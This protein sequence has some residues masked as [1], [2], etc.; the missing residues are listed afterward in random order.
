MKY[1]FSLCVIFLLSYTAQ[2]QSYMRFK[3]FYREN[4]LSSNTVE[5][6][7]QD[8]YDFMWI[9]T[10]NGLNKFDGYH[11]EIFSINDKDRYIP[12]DY[13]IFIKEDSNKRLWVI[14]SSSTLLYNRVLNRFNVVKNNVAPATFLLETKNKKI[15]FATHYGMAYYDEDKQEICSF[16]DRYASNEIFP[17]QKI[18][19]LL[20]DDNNNLLVGTDTSGLYIFNAR[21][22]L[23][24]HISTQTH[25][26]SIISN[27]ISCMAKDS[28]GNIWVGYKDKGVDYYNNKLDLIKHFEH[29]EKDNTTLSG[30]V[31]KTIMVDTRN[32]VWIGSENGG[33]NIYDIYKDKMT[34]I[35]HMV[36]F[37]EGL[38]Q[39]TVSAI[40]Q[41]RQGNVWIGTHRGGLNLYTDSRNAFQY[42]TH[43]FNNKSLSF[44]DVKYFSEDKN[45]N[46]YI[47]IDG[48]GLN[49]WKRNQ[50][51]FEHYKHDSQNS[52]T[53]ST[54][55]ILCTY[56]DKEGIVWIGTWEGGLNRFDPLSKK[57]TLYKNIPGQSNSI[58]SNKIWKIIEDQKEVLW[59]GTSE[60]GVSLYDKK[61][62]TF[63]KFTASKSK[64]SFLYGEN[65]HDIDIDKNKDIWISTNGG[66]L[67]RYQIE[68]D[69]ITHYFISKQ[70]SGFYS[71]E[72]SASFSDRDGNFWVAV[73]NRLY[74]FDFDNNIFIL[75]NYKNSAKYRIISITDDRD[76]NLWCGTQ[77]GIIKIHKKSKESTQYTDV[78]GL[79]G[80][81]FTKNAA[82]TLQDGHIIFGGYN[83][84]NI[85]EPTRIVKNTIPPKVYIT[86]LSV[87]NNEIQPSNEKNA[88]LKK[89]ILDNG[90]IELKSKEASLF[91]VEFAALN[92]ISTEKNNFAYMMQGLD[93]KWTNLGTERKITFNNLTP[94]N[95][96]LLVRASNNDDVW[97]NQGAKLQIAILP[98]FWQSWIFKILLISI[99]SLII[100]FYFLL[101]KKLL[102]R[103]IHERKTEEV[104]NMQLDFFTHIS[105]EFRTPLSLI[106]G[107]TEKIENDNKNINNKGYFDLINK[108]IERMIRL[109]KEIIDFRKVESGTVKLNIKEK[110]LSTHVRRI[111][112]DFYTIAE[113]KRINYSVKIVNGEYETQ[114]F[115]HQILESIIMNLLDNA[116]KYTNN[117]GSISI[118]ILDTLQA[119]K[120]TY[121]SKI[122]YKS[123]SKDISEEDIKYI[124]VRDTGIGISDKS[125]AHLFE[126]Y[127]RVSSKH[128]GSGL[129]LAYIK[130]LTMLHKGT[131]H[132]FSERF[133]GTDIIIGLPVKEKNY[134]YQEKNNIDDTTAQPY[135]Y[136]KNLLADIEE[137]PIQK[138]LITTES[139]THEYSI[140]IVEDNEDLRKFIASI[141]KDKYNIIEA[142][143]GVEGLKNTMEYNPSLIITD[144]M[145]PEMD[146]I[147]MCKRIKSNT[148]QSHIPIIML[149]AK[150]SEQSKREGMES[151]ADYYFTKPLSMSL[152]KVTI[153]NIFEHIKHIKT[154]YLSNYQYEIREK[155]H[156]SKEREIIDAL[157]LIVEN[158]M[159]NPDL[160]VNYLCKQM[161][162]SKTKL[163]TTVKQATGLSITE[164][165]R[166][167]RLKKAV[168]I[169]TNED[170]TIS[171]IMNRV[172]ILSASYFTKAFK[173]HFDK[174]PSEYYYSIKNR[175]LL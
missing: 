64:K 24:Q 26:K 4:G 85:F 72:I 159:D 92:F 132:V 114:W 135:I 140:L 164:F 11:F 110:S 27:G 90:K 67:N 43:G 42:Y 45:G 22:T 12:D 142:E 10:A 103:A 162:M 161:G 118:E 70:S 31:T 101:Y 106:L 171:E 138:E 60:G 36:Y 14:T 95:Y 117:G 172:G 19:S 74:K 169:M 21:H 167:A 83:G 173:K 59:I 153:E 130:S 107:A 41:D 168:A 104:Y 84:F 2:G 131:I 157:M 156:S 97:N 111:A 33:M 160:N 115:D 82:L 34:K 9:A 32:R 99:L 137:E 119:Y 163:Y 145:M 76:G 68:K 55:A 75:Y 175:Q 62:N 73:S 66:G 79:Q 121:K 165:I 53:I 158:Q 113:A 88:I 78:D 139:N 20:E 39:K 123:N 69:T 146:G 116:F 125:L 86:N 128:I 3:H 47:S 77:S 109:I 29:D 129:G 166:T 38:S 148:E 71:P 37:P 96:T 170:V 1:L 143:N 149:T 93:D 80:L 144:I 28:L 5:W 94:G 48:G 6:I 91:T 102:Q 147:E 87:L 44:K 122:I 151:G 13:I 46:V 154:H 23:T 105:H 57:F 124:I 120:P 56:I 35:V 58:S 65:V 25:K 126:R 133:K 61:S 40:F 8:S 7:F 112:E 16:N 174:T 81:D 63:S 49:L 127:Y 50:G 52:N 136:T 150:D 18:N 30:N 155:I 108:N 54:D 100:Y 15:L 51:V 89:Q 141:L 98:S 152:L 134:T 17:R